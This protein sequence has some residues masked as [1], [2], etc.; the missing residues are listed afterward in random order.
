[1]TPEIR[2][3]YADNLE[4]QAQWQCALTLVYNEWPVSM[5]R[6]KHDLR[7]IHR[8]VDHTLLGRRFHLRPPQARSWMWA[9]VEKTDTYAHVHA[10]WKLPDPHG[11]NELRRML[12][13]GLWLTFAP[14]GG[15]DLQEYKV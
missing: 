11:I 4:D 9:V 13:G 2:K 14:N 3:A 15:Y 12:D 7:G 6:I 8:I 1:M 5:D 10:G